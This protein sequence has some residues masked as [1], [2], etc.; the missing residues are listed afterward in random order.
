[1]SCGLTATTS[2][3]AA[4][5]GVGDVDGR[6]TPWRAVSSRGA[7]GMALG[8]HQLVGRATRGEQPRQQRLTD[9]ARPQH[10]DNA[11]AGRLAPGRTPFRRV[12]GG[13]G[14]AG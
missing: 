5:G 4:R 12:G 8:E 1:M 2:T 13:Y 9:L 6:A 3:S 10:R 11:H 14:A 7:L